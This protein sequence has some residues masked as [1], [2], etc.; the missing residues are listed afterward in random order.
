MRWRRCPCIRRGMWWEER[1]ANGV[2]LTIGLREWWRAKLTRDGCGQN[3]EAVRF[4]PR[5]DPRLDTKLKQRGGHHVSSQQW[6]HLLPSSRRHTL[7]WINRRRPLT[8]MWAIRCLSRLWQ[9]TSR[10]LQTRTSIVSRKEKTMRV[11]DAW[12]YDPFDLCRNG[13]HLLWETPRHS[14]GPASWKSVVE[15]TRA[16]DSWYVRLTAREERHEMKDIDEIQRE[17]LHRSVLSR[18][19]AASYL[20]FHA[21]L[22]FPFLWALQLHSLKPGLFEEAEA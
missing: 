12:L 22:S 10:I 15:P 17:G 6:Q 13:L 8:A 7:R 20:K 21:N 4:L 16:L 1:G 11:V 14:C 3:L 5:V 18:R 19:K 2:M 9:S